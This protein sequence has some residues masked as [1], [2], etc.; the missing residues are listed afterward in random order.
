METN[1]LAEDFFDGL[2]PAQ[3]AA[4]KCLEGPMLVIAGA[5]SGK[6]RVL[7]M[8][9]ANLIC[10]GIR[11][12][13]ILALTFTNKAAEEMKERIAQIVGQD[14]AHQ[15]WM[16]TFH[17]VFARIL[18]REAPLLSL[19]SDYTIYD[20]DDSEG[21]IKVIVKNMKLDDKKYTPKT[22]HNFISEAKN[23]LIT[24][25]MY[26]ESADFTNRDA[27]KH[28]GRMSEVYAAYEAEL[29][30]ANA[31]DFD[32]LLLYTNRLFR[33]FPDALQ[34]WQTRFKHILVDEY[35]DTNRAQYVIINRLA[36]AHGNICV[37]GDDA[38]SIYS[39]RGAKIENILNFG[40]DYCACKTFKL[41]QNY[42]STQNIVDA[43]NSLIK[44]NSRQLQ[45]NVFSEGEEGEKVNVWESKS[46]REEA[47][48][49]VRDI[50]SRM[51]Y[52]GLTPSEFAILYRASALTRVLEAE[53]RM[54]GLPYR[55]IGGQAFYQRK[56]V[57]DVLAYLKLMNNTDDVQSLRRVINVPQRGIGDTTMGKIET[58]LSS[59]PELTL[60]QTI[61]T[62]MLLMQAGISAGTQKRISVFVSLIEM[63][64]KEMM[65]TGD[66]YAL[67][68]SVVEKT[69]YATYLRSITDENERKERT[70][71]VEE[72]LRGMQEFSV[73]QTDADTEPTLP[74][75][76]QDVSLI[77][78][79]NNESDGER[80]Q[81]MTIHASKGLEFEVVYVVGVEENLFP[82]SMAMYDPMAIEEERRLMYVAM[83]RAR[84]VCTISYATSRFRNGSIQS[85]YKSRF[86]TDI[87][88]RYC[89]LPETN[90]FESSFSGFS[91]ERSTQSG[92]LFRAPQNR[93]TITYKRPIQ[94]KTSA[95][96]EMDDHVER[97]GDGQFGVGDVVE[98]EK[99]GR[100]QIL[101]ITGQNF[102]DQR[103]RIAFK[104]VGEKVLL[105][106]FS[107]LRK[108]K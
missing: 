14:M 40:K 53:L 67:G 70:E 68:R 82:S 7:T 16:G 35:Q 54:A 86:V 12:G 74:N 47:S 60:W 55:I 36:K 65:N 62:P 32:D 13:N 25:Q 61:S 100:G 102:Q 34:R 37:V 29:H 104:S 9:I 24:P 94:K 45:K 95:Q 63:L 43:A 106:K 66:L 10:N 71:N 85:T 18:R 49:V 30:K 42:R 88:S 6:T 64:R 21:L 15:L 2:N 22:V 72:L 51:R 59:E 73:S 76:L 99:F 23:E 20:S 33:D 108:A 80:V 46:D 77:T 26:A 48:R 103:L 69:G 78:D 5:G 84:R 96:V 91:G 38:Q 50:V 87:D 92:R 57:K 81:L 3:E 8:R 93:P 44:H 17:S 52:D 83:T 4:V 19:R 75:F 28:M 31:L 11:P 41:E 97:T 89:Q 56:E 27:S 58:Y 90:G 39:F 1:Y 98:H 107:R 79:A 105:L 101:S